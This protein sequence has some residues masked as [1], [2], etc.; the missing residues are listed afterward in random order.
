MN[1]TSNNEAYHSQGEFMVGVLPSAGV[2]VCK[3][4]G[5]KS[6]QECVCMMWGDDDKITYSPPATKQ[7]PRDDDDDDD[8]D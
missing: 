7:D 2:G 1:G 6:K 4:E 5:P 8:N 3:E